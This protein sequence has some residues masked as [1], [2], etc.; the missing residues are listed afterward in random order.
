MRRLY[1]AFAAVWL[2]AATSQAAELKTVTQTGKAFHPDT[3]SLAAG[4]T[5]RIAN[6]DDYLHHVYVDHPNLKFDSGGRKPGQTV[7]I[8]FAKPGTYQ[9]RCDIH[10]KMLLMVDVR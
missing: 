8:Q 1:V 6:D 3:V 7:D 2:V 5:L 10:P 4:D 9:V